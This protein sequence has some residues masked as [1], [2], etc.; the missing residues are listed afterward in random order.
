MSLFSQHQIF[1]NFKNDE[2]I[3]VKHQQK[4]IK[5]NSVM[6]QWRWWEMNSR[7]SVVKDGTMKRF[8]S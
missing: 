8:W 4:E 6:R 7:W 3:S 2:I 5:I 1:L